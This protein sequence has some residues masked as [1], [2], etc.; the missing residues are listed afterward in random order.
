MTPNDTRHHPT[1]QTLSVRRLMKKHGL[2]EPSAAL[3]AALVYGE[4]WNV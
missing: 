1:P 2:S 3:I 4:G